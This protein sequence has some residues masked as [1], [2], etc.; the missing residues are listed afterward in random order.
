[1]HQN[2]RGL[3]NLRGCLAGPL[4]AKRLLSLPHIFVSRRDVLGRRNFRRPEDGRR[5]RLSKGLQ[6]RGFFLSSEPLDFF[7]YIDAPTP[8]L[9][10]SIY[11]HTTKTAGR[12]IYSVIAALVP[13]VW[14]AVSDTEFRF[15]C[16]FLLCSQRPTMKAIF[17]S[18]LS[19]P[20]PSVY[21]AD[22]GKDGKNFDGK[23][24]NKTKLYVNLT[25]SRGLSCA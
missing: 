3:L 25:R 5:R 19:V 9:R 24:R 14:S 23:K 2:N 15:I 22:G 10:G 8:A 7:L 6:L 12:W 4:Q 18:P 13:L 11:V 21:T 20:R 16:L 17:W 1:M